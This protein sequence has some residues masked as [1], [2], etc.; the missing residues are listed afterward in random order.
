M[1]FDKELHIKFDAPLRAGDTEYQTFGCR[2]N[3]PSICKN[4]YMNGVCAF[5]T[6]DRICRKPTNAWK[7]QYLK[8]KERKY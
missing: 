2:A 5:C 7:R 8:L 3:N 4:A 6:A 1:T